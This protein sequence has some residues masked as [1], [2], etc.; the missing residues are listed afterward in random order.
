MNATHEEWRPVARDRGYEVSNLG[1]VRSVDRI[2]V[3][4]IGR[5][6]RYRGR[7]LTPQIAKDGSGRPFI[8]L[9]GVATRVHTLVAEAFIGPRPE[10]MFVCHNNGDPADNRVEN[11]RYDSPR[12]NSRD[13]LR[14]G[15]HYEANATHCLRGHEFTPE[16]TY[17]RRRPNG[18]AHRRCRECRR[19]LRRKAA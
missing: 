13:I 17:A 18:N 14:H 12:E 11:L 2:K 19:I 9:S 3:D 4:S 5:R 16:N 1:R 10:G 7:I 6:G 15:R 8:R